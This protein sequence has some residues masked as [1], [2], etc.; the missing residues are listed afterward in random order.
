MKKRPY[1]KP[2]FPPSRWSTAQDSYLIENST[3]ADQELQLQLPFSLDE[4]NERKEILGLIRRRRQ[5]RKLFE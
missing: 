2:E 3:L 1:R 5:L 4:I